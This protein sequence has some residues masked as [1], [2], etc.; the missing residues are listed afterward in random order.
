MAAKRPRVMDSAVTENL[1]G[2]IDWTIN[3][4][5]A[6]WPACKKLESPD[7]KFYFPE[8]HRT[9][10]FALIVVPSTDNWAR[11]AMINRNPEAVKMTA[12]VKVGSQS[13][14]FLGVLGGNS[15][16][17]M[18]EFKLT[19]LIAE[20]S[21][22]ENVLLIRVN[23]CLCDVQKHT[24]KGL[25]ENRN[26]NH[27]FRQT[28][29][30]LLTDTTFSDFTIQCGTEKFP[31]HKAILANRSDVFARLLSSTD[32]AENKK[33]VFQVDNHDPATVKQMLE[34]IYTNKLPE[35]TRGS[36][37]LLFIADQFNMKDLISF[38]ELDISRQVSPEN[39]IKIL[40]NVDKVA[41]A[42]CLKNFVIQFISKNILSLVGTDDW[43]EIIDPN[44]DL[45]EAIKTFKV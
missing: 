16:L 18:F 2:Q 31:C 36:V 4:F 29:K 23:F 19:S 35:G 22:A 3:N 39:A 24:A 41:E 26:T 20:I 7:F 15:R 8:V 45:L 30:A 43:K 1:D 40:G 27:L 5:L 21:A 12:T 34:F 14:P 10:R 28:L 9:L 38:C 44:P 42:T 32:W 25:F 11:I 33:N 37:E 13:Y 17:K 6:T